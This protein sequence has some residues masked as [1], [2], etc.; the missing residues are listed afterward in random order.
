MDLFPCLAAIFTKE[1][2]YYDFLFASLDNII[3]PNGTLTV[4][5]LFK[6]YLLLNCLPL[7]RETKKI[8]FSYFPCKCIY[9]PEDNRVDLQ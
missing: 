1:Y 4:K 6:S 3:L 8:G 2:K 5:N 7:R 9:L